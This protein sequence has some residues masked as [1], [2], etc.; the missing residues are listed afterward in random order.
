MYNSNTFKIPYVC[1]Y[2]IFFHFF[3]DNNCWIKLS[4]KKIKDPHKHVIVFVFMRTLFIT[5]N[6]IKRI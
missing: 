6:I 3:I 5:I 2:F 4:C 1:S